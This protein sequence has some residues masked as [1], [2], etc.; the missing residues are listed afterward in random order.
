MR[1]IATTVTSA[2]VA[3]V[4]VACGPLTGDGQPPPTSPTMN[5]MTYYVNCNAV[6]AADAAPLRRGEPGYRPPLDR[7]GDGVA[8][9][10]ANDDGE[11][12]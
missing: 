8:C 6:R 10:D 11:D 7:D 12:D 2:L 9:D 5:R 1:A 3:L 4:T